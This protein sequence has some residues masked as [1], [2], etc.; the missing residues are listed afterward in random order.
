MQ[1]LDVINA[2]ALEPHIEGG[3]FHRSYTSAHKLET[4]A[5]QRD[6]LSCIYY[7]LDQA[8]AVGHWHQNQSDILHFHQG[9]NAIRYSLIDLTG[10]L[11]QVILGPDLLAGQQLQLVVPSGYWKASELIIKSE[12]QDNWG[13]ISEVVTP[14][15]DYQD[16]KLAT[17]QQMQAQYPTLFLQ[18]EHLIRN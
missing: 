14:G 6:S 13:L 9:G 15:F 1:S 8:S 18:I 4:K 2:L 7:L 16:M 17:R 3:Y 12:Q 5:G 10:N 11:S